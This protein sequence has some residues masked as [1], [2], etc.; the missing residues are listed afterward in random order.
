VSQSSLDQEATKRAIA[1]MS[2]SVKV[3]QVRIRT[4]LWVLTCALSSLYALPLYAQEPAP[5]ASDAGA[6]DAP[7]EPRPTAA[8]PEP[9]TPPTPAAEPAMVSETAPA[10][11][12]AEIQVTTSRK[13]VEAVQETPVAVSVVS[14]RQLSGAEG[15][16]IHSAEDLSGTV[17]SFNIDNQPTAAGLVAL[18]IRGISFVDVQKSFDMPI[19]VVIDGVYVG[20][21]SG[22]NFQ[23]FDLQSVEVLR[24][25]Q[26]TLFGR[27]TTGGLL[28]V[29][30]VLP[31]T[32][33]WVAKIQAR[34]GSFGQR[35]LMGSVN[36]PIVRDYVGLK[37]TGSWINMD[38]WYTNRSQEFP[39]TDSTTGASNPP[40]TRSGP[41]PATHNLDGIADL[42]ITPFGLDS[43]GDPKDLSVRLKYEHLRMRGTYGGRSLYPDPTT[44]ECSAPQTV[45]PALPGLPPRPGFTFTERY[46]SRTLT[47]RNGQTATLGP[48]DSIQGWSHNA[49]NADFNMV[50]GEVNYDLNPKYKIVS[51]TG[52]RHSYEFLELEAD[53]IP[54]L[55][56]DST[57]IYNTDQISE[58]LRLHGSPTRTVNFV[59]GGLLWHSYYNFRSPTE[60]ALQ[61]NAL[62]GLPPGLVTL[63][64]SSQDTISV[65][66]FGQADWEFVKNTRLTAGVRYTWEQKEFHLRSG[67]ACPP[68]SSV[69]PPFQNM[70]STLPPP[71]NTIPHPDPDGF[72]TTGLLGMGL[73]NANPPAK[74]WANLSPRAG[75][76][77]KLDHSVM[78]AQNGGL[79]YG[80]YSRG[81][82]SGGFNGRA[83]TAAEVVPFD[84]EFVDQFEAGIKTAWS[85]NRLIVNVA[86]F[87]TL[88]HDKQEFIQEAAPPGSTTATLTIPRNAAQ[89][90]IKGF[91]YEVQAMPLKGQD[92]PLVGN[93]RLW[94]TGSIL[95]A[96]YDDFKAAFGVNPMTNM[97]NPIADFSGTR[98]ARAPD[99]QTAV[100][101]TIPFE[102]N[103]TNRIILDGQVRYRTEMPLSFV[104]DPTG[105]V[106]D[107]LANSVAAHRVDASLSYEM[108]Q[109]VNSLSGRLTVYGR[110]LTDQVTWGVLGLAPPLTWLS[111]RMPPRSFGAEL[112]V[113][114]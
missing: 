61:Q 93:F 5:A 83:T 13:R 7:A 98:L 1:S 3:S 76:D 80:T 90:S 19:G 4:L 34:A 111:S 96:R 112:A 47:T 52:W 27:N 57:Q 73:I 77:Y 81:F 48:Y 26:G 108:D 41:E 68:M 92:V 107:P 53:S 101:A 50:T 36:V 45:P 8:P 58:E 16:K 60:N 86:G 39:S 102:L 110:N 65:A 44:L 106:R 114:Y 95:D 72:A 42:L 55:L 10:K 56:A 25:P 14:A 12:G 40:S 75:L 69:C 17:P 67:V 78:G 54:Q 20:S 15:T 51:V 71:L 28:N 82:H 104:V 9:E 38:G 97:P 85:R 84:P 99:F 89:A 31:K 49:N 59:A 88:F 91:E 29:R 62:A 66:G 35:D 6:P 46:C 64:I 33:E 22:I 103:P 105:Q 94:T 32:D 21:N 113:N 37:V 24:G 87:Y 79:L 43:R 23:N 30:T 63:T 74:S 70:D 100:G 109:I 11:E 2:S 18:S